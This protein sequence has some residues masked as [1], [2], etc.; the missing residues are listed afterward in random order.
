L[1]LEE[2]DPPRA[3]PASDV[4]P[5][6][7]QRFQESH[8][9]KLPDGG[10]ELLLDLSRV[11]QPAQAD[12]LAGKNAEIEINLR[13]AIEPLVEEAKSAFGGGE[14]QFEVDV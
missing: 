6:L 3:G 10:V 14:F 11:V 12:V 1:P 13:G 9:L 8:A 5:L 7:R 4:T 2:D